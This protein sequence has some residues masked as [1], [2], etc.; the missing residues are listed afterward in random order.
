MSKIELID[1][2][3]SEDGRRTL[4]FEMHTSDFGEM[5]ETLIFTFDNDEKLFWSVELVCR[6]PFR[7]GFE[8]LRWRLW[9]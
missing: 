1:S 3:L 4:V 5:P 2:P 8:W 9:G 7:T 6:G